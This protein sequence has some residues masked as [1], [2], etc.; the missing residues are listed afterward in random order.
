MYFE[1]IIASIK[2]IQNNRCYNECNIWS[3]FQKKEWVEIKGQGKLN[4]K[5]WFHQQESTMWSNSFDFKKWCF[6][7]F[8]FLGGSQKVLHQIWKTN[9]PM[10]GNA[11]QWGEIFLLITVLYLY[12]YAKNSTS[13]I[14]EMKKILQKRRL[15]TH[16]RHILARSV[17]KYCA[18]LVDLYNMA[19]PF[20][21]CTLILVIINHSNNSKLI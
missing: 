14:I 16:V 1:Q 4:L 7:S 13:W 3:A 5:S 21:I 20:D 6:V 10:S 9:P 17:V 12:M 15:T 2:K 8:L 18:L 19:P 11:N